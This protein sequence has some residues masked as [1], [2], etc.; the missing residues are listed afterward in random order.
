[1]RNLEVGVNL[2]VGAAEVGL[3]GTENITNRLGI[4]GSEL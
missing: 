2:M 1:M 3:A 4:C